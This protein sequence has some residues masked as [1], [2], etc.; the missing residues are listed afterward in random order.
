[1]SEAVIGRKGACK[2]PL[3]ICWS[4]FSDEID[5]FPLDTLMVY[6]E[7]EMSLYEQEQKTYGRTV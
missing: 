1:M 6:F 4:P 3:I 2:V 7:Q 5:N